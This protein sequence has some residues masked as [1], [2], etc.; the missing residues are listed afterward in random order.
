MG[1]EDMASRFACKTRL[2]GDKHRFRT[3]DV[4][5]RLAWLAAERNQRRD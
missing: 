1:R 3:T 4:G 2:V 5:Y